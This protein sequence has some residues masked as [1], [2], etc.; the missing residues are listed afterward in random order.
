MFCVVDASSGFY[1]ILSGSV[2]SSSVHLNSLRVR[3][4]V[5]DPLTSIQG[6]KIF[7]PSMLKNFIYPVIFQK[8]PADPLKIKLYFL[9]ADL[10]FFVVI[11]DKALKAFI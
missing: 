8:K 4:S 1:V 2:T 6:D 10:V 9:T 3:G 7:K 5:L 11:F